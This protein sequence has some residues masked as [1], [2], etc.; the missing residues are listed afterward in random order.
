MSGIFIFKPY[1]ENN[2]EYIPYFQEDID[3]KDEDIIEQARR[4]FKITEM[5]KLK[6]ID[7]INFLLSEIDE[8]EPKGA[9]Y[10]YYYSDLTF[11]LNHYCLE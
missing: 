6:K 2:M 7:L 1:R 3:D 4:D 11:I 5:Y 9:Y 8:L 10:G